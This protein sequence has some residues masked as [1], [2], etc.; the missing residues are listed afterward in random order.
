MISSFKTTHKKKKEED[1]LVWSE[2]SLPPALEALYF[3]NFCFMN[4]IWF[5]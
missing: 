3:D 2:E 4:N 1:E 5:V